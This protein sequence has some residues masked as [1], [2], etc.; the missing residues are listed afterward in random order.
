MNSGIYLITNTVTGKMYV[1]QSKR[2]SKRFWRHKDA[3]KTQNPREAFYLHRAMAKHGV[4]NFKFEVLLYA[5]DSDYLNLMERNCISTYNTLSPNGYNLDTGGGVEK[6]LSEET[7]QKLS[8]ALKGRPCPTKGRPHSEETKAKMSA[9]LKGRKKTEEHIKNASA[10]RTGFKHSEETKMK[11]RAV[12]RSYLSS[13]EQ[14]ARLKA[15]WAA[16]RISKEK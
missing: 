10:A 6:K 16:K 15:A 5:K 3:V 7:K 14:K 9:A 1:G 11:M 8:I 13:P 4:E 2:I 12:D